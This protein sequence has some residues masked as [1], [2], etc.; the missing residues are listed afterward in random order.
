M[1][2]SKEDIYIDDDY[3]YIIMILP[4]VFINTDIQGL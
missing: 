2:G 1:S 3:Y 4:S